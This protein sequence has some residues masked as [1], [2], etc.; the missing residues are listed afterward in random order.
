MAKSS[1]SGKHKNASSLGVK[2]PQYNRQTGQWENTDKLGAMMQRRSAQ[3]YRVAEDVK[4]KSLNSA[5]KKEKPVHHQFLTTIAIDIYDFAKAKGA[6]SKGALLVLAQASLESGYGASAIKNDDYNLFGVMGKP[7]KRSTSHGTVKDYS[8]LGGYQAALTDYFNKIDKN[9][10]YF[11]TIIT[12]DTITAD[13]IDKAFNTGKYYPTE[14]ERHGGKYT[15]NADKDAAGKNHYGEHLLNQI[16]DFKKRFKK[17]LDY[18]IEV[19]KERLKEINT[20]L[21]NN[22]LLFT[23]PGKIKLEDEKRSLISQNEKFNSIS[24]EIN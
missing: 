21:T 15:Y 7:S 16:G 8:T 14:K 17:S 24:N 20:L 10:S 1:S 6:S 13:D 22:S 5:P 2:G 18:Q 4:D 9:W 11:S 19:N 12:K 23:D 3:G